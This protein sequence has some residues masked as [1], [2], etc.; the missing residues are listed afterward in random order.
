MDKATEAW[1]LSYHAP[2]HMVRIRL[3]TD[4]AKQLGFEASPGHR[5]SWQKNPGP[6]TKSPSDTAHLVL[7]LPLQTEWDVLCDSGWTHGCNFGLGGRPSHG[8]D[9]LWQVPK[10]SEAKWPVPQV[11]LPACL[12]NA[13]LLTF[14]CTV[15]VTGFLLG[16]SGKNP[17]QLC[18]CKHYASGYELLTSFSVQHVT[19]LSST[20]PRSS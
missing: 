18:F 19:S 6:L 9:Y 11:L 20:I 8:P 12:G 4:F 3:C 13:S 2:H 14:S 5:V 16:A 1:D 17:R 10:A 7:S 15:T